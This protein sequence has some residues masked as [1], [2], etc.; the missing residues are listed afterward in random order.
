MM[1]VSTLL[2]FQ[3][4][5]ARRSLTYEFTILASNIIINLLCNRY[6]MGGHGGADYHLMNNWV[7]AVATQNWSRVGTTADDALAS[8]LLVF[9]AEESRKRGSV[10]NLKGNF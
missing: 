9:A 6:G 7:N 5:W 4:H 8:H 3:T 10:V 2:L 1:E